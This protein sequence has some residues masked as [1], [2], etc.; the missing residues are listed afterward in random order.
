MRDWIWIGSQYRIHGGTPRLRSIAGCGIFYLCR[1]VDEHWQADDRIVCDLRWVTHQTKSSLAD[2][3]GDEALRRFL[4]SAEQK[5]VDDVWLSLYEEDAH[6]DASLA[7]Q[8]SP[9]ASR[10]RD[11]SSDCYLPFLSEKLDELVQA[12]GRED[13]AETR[14]WAVSALK[15]LV[16]KSDVVPDELGYLGLVDDLHVLEQA[17]QIVQGRSSWIALLQE[18]L[19]RWPFLEQLV[20]TDGGR[21]T[22]LSPFLQVV[23][24]NIQD[25]LARSL[26]TTITL[27]ECGPSALLAAFVATLTSVKD[28][29]KGMRKA[30]DRI[31]RGAPVELRGSRRIVRAVYDGVDDSSGRRLHWVRLQDGA[32]QGLREE[33]AGLLHPC[34][35]HE[36]L[37]T[38]GDFR[39][40]KR[41]YHPSPLRE[42]LGRDVDLDMIKPTVLLVTPR[43]SLDSFSQV[44]VPLGAKISKLVGIRYITR[45]GRRQDLP[46]S[47]CR[48]PLLWCCNDH[49]IAG[50]LAGGGEPDFQPKCVVVDGASLASG[51][52]CSTRT[53]TSGCTQLIVAGL[54]EWEE[55]RHL[56]RLGFES[57]LLRQEDVD[58]RGWSADRATQAARRPL[59][60][61]MHRQSYRTTVDRINHLVH[62]ERIEGL[63]ALLKTIRRSIDDNEDPRLQTVAFVGTTLL[64]R[65]LEL[66]IGP[67][68]SA[69]AMILAYAGKTMTA[70]APFVH[71]DQSVRELRRL[72]QSLRDD[73]PTSPRDEIVRDLIVDASGAIAVLCATRRVASACKELAASHPRLAEAHWIPVGSLNELPPVDTIVIPGFVDR[74][75]MRILHHSPR[76]SWHHHVVLPF[77]HIWLTGL[78][79]RS[80][81]WEQHLCKR[82]EH[83]WSK[84][85]QHYGQVGPSPTK[86]VADPEPVTPREDAPEAIQAQED[87]TPSEWLEARVVGE[88]RRHA[89]G[90]LGTSAEAVKARLV[91]FE[92]PG[93]YVMLPPGAS[94]ICLSEVIESGQTKELSERQVAKGAAE[95]IVSRP[96]KEIRPGHLLAFPL[97]RS[98]DL[99]DAIADR[100]VK[101]APK[102]REEALSW[103]R[104]LAK[105]CYEEGLSPKQLAERLAAAGLRRQ[106]ATV[107][108]WLH[109]TSTIAPQNWRSDLAVIAEVTGC[110]HLRTSLS[111]VLSSI[112]LLYRARR[113]AAGHL[114]EQ[115]GHGAVDLEKGIVSVTVEGEEVQYRLLH[116][117]CVDDPCMIPPSRLARLSQLTEEQLFA[118]LDTEGLQ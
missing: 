23:I 4:T 61:F 85:A 108:G 62:D 47:D 7:E 42:L 45:N 30:L 110:E 32:R 65:L 81:D 59:T 113:R 57:R 82:M 37:S 25:A 118:H 74:Q 71:Y 28:Q 92:E 75:T 35:P 1:H 95:K 94:V 56:E 109:S 27:P 2:E 18:F 90:G 44:L 73:P 6:L 9:Y 58:P 80:R 26:P 104:A 54:H 55:C 116:V 88:I 105:F 114:I 86:P 60:D 72:V 11:L 14:S 33:L 99:L 117:R 49:E 106:A 52:V 36:E 79:R 103:K 68:D 67:E 107:S 24:G 22:S 41:H 69:R 84:M 100:L 112:D 96:L 91:V 89:T 111:E 101:D 29:A 93:W 53:R 21:E 43:K 17:H 10:F 70:C 39:V 34:E 20:F 13:E 115:I 12:A 76:A 64:R 5:A 40:W 77:E 98:G 46:G 16:L 66:V 8:L 102:V 97:D 78:R 19:D 48:V 87:A 38:T 63:H 31:S 83:H 3:L 15:Y 51:E 50:R